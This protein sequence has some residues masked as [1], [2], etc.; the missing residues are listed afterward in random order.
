MT[1]NRLNSRIS[2]EISTAIDAPGKILVSLDLEAH[3]LLQSRKF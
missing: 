2:G 3:S 1:R